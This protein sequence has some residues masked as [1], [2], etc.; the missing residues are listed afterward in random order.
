[1][2]KLSILSLITGVSLFANIDMIDV[3]VEP[4]ES[5]IVNIDSVDID[6]ITLYSSGV[7]YFK[8][9]LDVKKNSS[10]VFP[11]LSKN[12]SDILQS[13]MVNS[14]NF[15]LN[16]Q[17]PNFLNKKLE[18]IGVNPLSF[19]NLQDFLGFYVG[20]EIKVDARSKKVGKILNIDKKSYVQGEE[21]ILSLFSDEGIELI[22]LRD[23]KSISFTDKKINKE[24]QKALGLLEDSKNL[25][26]NYIKLIFSADESSVDISYVITVRA[27]KMSYRLNIG[28]NSSANLLGVAI[29][30]NSTK[31]DWDSSKITLYTGKPNIISSDLYSQNVLLPNQPVAGARMALKARASVQEDELM[32]TQIMAEH[33]LAQQNSFSKQNSEQ[34]YFKIDSNVTIKSEQSVAIPVISDVLDIREFCLFDNIRSNYKATPK[35]S[36]EIKNGSK[37]NYV[38]GVVSVYNSAGFIGD[39]R[40]DYLPINDKKFLS[41]SED[42]MVSGFKTVEQTSKISAVS[43]KNGLMNIKSSKEIDSNYLIENF[44]NIEKNILIKQYVKPNYALVENKDFYS[45]NGNDYEFNLKVAPNDKSNLNVKEIYEEQNSYL[46]SSLN[47]NQIAIYIKNSDISESVKAILSSVLNKKSELIEVQNKID[48]LNKELKELQETQKRVR[49][50]LLSVEKDS[51]IYKDFLNKLVSSEKSIED[52]YSKIAEL[53][54]NK[55]LLEDEY[56]KVLNGINLN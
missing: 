47:E 28:E 8:H 1:M 48:N 23:I 55:Q 34:F 42:P 44:S 7:G 19:Q 15:Y 56:L 51:E 38:S 43:I 26:D 4:K 22:N 33:A 32:D 9:S 52:T 54:K 11:F 40:L 6:K 49:E 5:L 50:N 46:I 14:K 30:E 3:K 27:W 24:L 31:Y 35:T 29:L 36:V 39:A 10:I 2:K 20:S 25:D 21:Y 13:L 53:R 16:Y 37:T 41:F 12:S 45:K 17:N 18:D